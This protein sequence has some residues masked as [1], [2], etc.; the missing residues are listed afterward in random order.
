MHDNSSNQSWSYLVKLLAEGL[1]GHSETI[2]MMAKRHF[3]SRLL[4]LCQNESFCK[5]IHMIIFI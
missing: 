3:L 5:T 4:S 2:H 1:S